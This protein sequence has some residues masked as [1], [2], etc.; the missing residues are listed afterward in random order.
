MIILLLFAIL[1]GLVTVLSPC[2]LPVLPIVLSSSMTGGKHRLIGVIAGLMIS[3][4]VFT[5]A[6]TQIVTILGLSAN[7]LRMAAIIII[8]VLGIGLIVPSLNARIERALSR[9]AVLSPQNSGQGSGFRSGFL[10]GSSLGLVWAPCAGPILA[11]VTTLAATQRL[12]WGAAAVVI[13][14]AFGTGI[15][16]L[17]IAYGGREAIRR[18]PLFIQNP[19]RLQQIFGG[20]MVLTAILIAV[21]ADT[22]VTAWATSLIPASWT[23][24]LNGFENSP[25]VSQKLAQLSQ[26]SRTPAPTTQHPLP[27]T[28]NFT[29]NAVAAADLPD[30]GSAPEFTGIDHWINST[31]LSIK[32]LRGKVV[33]V[34][35]W[36]Y[37]CI[38]CIRTLPYVT[39]WYSK[40]KADGF[41]VIGV[42]TPE[43]AFE[44]DPTNV[45]LAV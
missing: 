23:A 31:P 9:L 45:E 28:G 42:H 12:S 44:H 33:L 3:F 16:L 6:I 15:P 38:N 2:I 21:N 13:A 35:F 5:L 22:L 26:G 1:S 36:T 8:G 18:I 30:L 7:V 17:V 40:Y 43:F 10:T 24:Q 37:S 19:V 32:D 41:V 34:D 29:Q 20:V 27:Q 25:L 11:A 14:Y 4:S 39:S